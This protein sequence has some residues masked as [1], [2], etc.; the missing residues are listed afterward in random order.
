MLS[1]ILHYWLPSSSLSQ[2][3]PPEERVA[4][5]Y[6]DALSV[7]LRSNTA[8]YFPNEHHRPI[9]DAGITNLLELSLRCDLCI[10]REKVGFWDPDIP[11]VHVSMLFCMKTYLR[12]DIASLNARQPVVVS[13][14]Y[15]DQKWVD[16]MMLPL[17]DS[18]GE[19][20]GIVRDEG[21]FPRPVLSR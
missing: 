12:T 18:L 8:Y 17:D 20:Y 9:T 5:C 1:L 3:L 13:I 4:G 2:A 11:Q 6:Y 15:L 10:F 19:H 16:S 7:Y 21:E 14:L